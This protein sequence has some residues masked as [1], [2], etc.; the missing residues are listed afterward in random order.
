MPFLSF[1]LL[2]SILVLAGH[3]YDIG[4]TPPSES[5]GGD[6]G[7]GI[8]TTSLVGVL[9]LALVTVGVLVW[10]SRRDRETADPE[11]SATVNLRTL[12]PVA[13]TVMIIAAPLIVWTASSGGEDEKDLIVERFT[14]VT[15]DPELLLSLGNEDLNTPEAANGKRTVR[16]VCRG[17]QGQPV[18]DE[19]QKWPFILEKG[20]DYAHAHQ[21]A[22]P[23]QVQRADRCR[24]LGTRAKLDAGVE[25]SLTG[26]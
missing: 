8:G 7:G 20:Y 13:F 23:E 25:G 6:D 14:S 21:A 9:V 1:T 19:K 24:V 5:S 17:R 3:G 16:V 2:D 15:G 22:S 11:R 12:A 26:D 4:A 10:L 18:L